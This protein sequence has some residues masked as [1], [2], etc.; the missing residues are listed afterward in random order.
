MIKFD[1]KKMQKKYELLMKFIESTEQA[2]KQVENA[3]LLQ[4]QAKAS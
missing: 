2:G 3:K 1:K 4:R